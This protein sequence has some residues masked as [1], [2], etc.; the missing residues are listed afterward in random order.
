M[1]RVKSVSLLG[2]KIPVESVV[3]WFFLAAMD[4]RLQVFPA[5]WNRCLLSSK[6]FHAGKNPLLCNDVD[7][8]K[9]KIEHTVSFLKLAA[10]HPL[11][12]NMGCLRRSLVLRRELQNMG[13]STVLTYGVRK[14][15]GTKEGTLAYRGHA[16]L[17]I[18]E[19]V[20]LQGYE[21][22]TSSNPLFFQELSH[23]ES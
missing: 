11:Y 10:S 6:P 19:P 1:F 4:L 13:I 14:E 12:F 22:D 16:W 15:E 9:E 18:R 2:R 21:I 20:C 7:A 5:T 23:A 17:V 3:F 8:L